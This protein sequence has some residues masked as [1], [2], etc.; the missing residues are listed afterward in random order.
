M[1]TY[2]GF[3]LCPRELKTESS[4]KFWTVLARSH[5][6]GSGLGDGECYQD[7]PISA[8]IQAPFLI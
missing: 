2:D 1:P 4:L 5:I 6:T 8:F 3:R 7:G